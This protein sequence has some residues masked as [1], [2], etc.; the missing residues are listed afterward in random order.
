MTTKTKRHSRMKRVG[1][2]SKAMTFLD[3]VI[4]E[5][6][7]FADTLKTIRETD[8]LTQG[9]VAELIGVTRS[10]ICDIEK[11][12]KLVSPERAARFAKVLGYS[13]EQFVR[14][15]LQDQIRSAGLNMEVKVEAA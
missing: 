10:H 5:P 14:L 12:R 13:P 2:T 11:G 7:T 4:G 15:A 3:E 8:E 9:Q 1:T 6:M